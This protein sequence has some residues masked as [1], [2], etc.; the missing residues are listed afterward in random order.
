MAI[1]YWRG[2]SFVIGTVARPY[3]ICVRQRRRTRTIRPTE[4]LDRVVESR[5]FDGRPY[6]ARAVSSSCGGGPA[7]GTAAAL[8]PPS[9]TRDR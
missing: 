3:S 8:R 6:F 7:K 5:I 2:R 1:G 9:Q 4:T